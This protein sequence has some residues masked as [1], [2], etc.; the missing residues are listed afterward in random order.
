MIH[1][2][3]PSTLDVMRQSKIDFY[4]TGSQYFYGHG[5]DWDVFTKYD[6]YTINWLLDNGFHLH[7]SS[8]Y[9][10]S[11]CTEVYRNGMVDVQLVV[12][13]EL[14]NDVQKMFKEMGIL[15]PVTEQW[16]MAF[17]IWKRNH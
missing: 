16:N 11:N 3:T 17:E 4:L 5:K 6:H 9:T 13:V 7:S 12:D 1:G 14:K 15:K 10:D 2:F 8:A